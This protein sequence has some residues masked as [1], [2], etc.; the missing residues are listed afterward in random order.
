M[1]K[2]I[3][4]R[5]TVYRSNL[6]NQVC[7]LILMFFCYGLGNGL[8]YLDD[9]NCLGTET[10]LTECESTGLGISNCNHA[11]DAGVV[12][13]IGKISLMFIS[14]CVFMHSNNKTQ[15]TNISKNRRLDK[16]TLGIIL[17]AQHD[18]LW[19]PGPAV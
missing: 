10:V 12:C 9:L 17:G 7:V 5:P 8:I 15:I 16:E 2:Y 3:V 1:L 4:Y 19:I 13:A 6:I 14:V 18:D 11:E